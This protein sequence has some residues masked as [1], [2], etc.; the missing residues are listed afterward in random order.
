ME[1]LIKKVEQWFNDRG[2]IEGSTSGGQMI[3]LQEECGELAKSI[4]KNNDI[5]DDVG[6]ITVVLIGFCMRYGIK[7]EDCLKHAYSQIKDRKGIMLND[8]YMKEEDIY[9]DY[10]EVYYED[11]LKESFNLFL[12]EIEKDDAE[13]IYEGKKMYKKQYV[14]EF[15]D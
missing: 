14:N 5:T 6:D 15:I 11:E 10:E 1:E 12:C 13:I 2:I 7:F 3:K 8:V 9:E 4:R